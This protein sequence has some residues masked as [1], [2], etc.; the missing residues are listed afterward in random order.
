MFNYTLSIFLPAEVLM[1]FSPYPARGVQR[2]STSP[3]TMTKKLKKTTCTHVFF[4]L[5]KRKNSDVPTPAAK[6]A[7]E[8]AGLVERKITFPG[9]STS[10]YCI[11]SD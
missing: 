11:I 3:A 5:A 1:L 4:C 9:R 8:R 7:L 2:K 10:M 6:R